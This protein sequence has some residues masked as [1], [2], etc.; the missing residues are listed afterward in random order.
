MRYLF[1]HSDAAFDA[2]SKRW[3]FTLDR[4]ISNPRSIRLTKCVFTA[5]TATSYPSVVYLRSDALHR[6]TKT[7]HTVELKA[8]NH[9]NPS[10]VIAVLQETHTQGRYAISEKGVSLP[11]HGHTHA[12]EIDLYF[13]DGA[14][15]MDGEIAAGSVI[16]GGADDSTMEDLGSDLVLWIDPEYAPLSAQSTLV[17]VDDESVEYL[18]NR[19]PGTSEIML[20]SN[21][22]D[23]FILTSFGE[24]KAVIGGPQSAWAAMSDSNGAAV[25]VTCSMHFTFRAPPSSGAQVIVNMPK[26]MFTIRWWSNDLQFLD[27]NGSWDTITATNFLPNS[28]WYVECVNTDSDGN[29]TPTF[30]WRFI[31]LADLDTVITETTVGSVTS[32]SAT[33]DWLLSA[34]ND[35]YTVAISSVAVLNTGGPNKRDTIMNWMLSRYTTESSEEPPPPPQP[36]TFMV[37]L[38]V[39][40]SQR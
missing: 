28:E 36:A 3:K 25:D 14:T 31:N 26:D 30:D 21:N 16:G 9:E 10:N 11:V 5:S 37:E 8:N 19:S 20:V 1:H 35:H 39:K 38:E 13:T 18:R 15:V 4:R 27:N 33:A 12:R 17:T 23:Q 40:Q 7:K 29:G 22:T 6:M 34:A 24:T 32:K 2:T